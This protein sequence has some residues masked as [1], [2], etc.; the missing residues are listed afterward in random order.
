MNRY[1]CKK[2]NWSGA[3]VCKLADPE[4]LANILEHDISLEKISFDTAEN[5]RLNFC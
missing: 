2:L 1:V 4:K 3:E 5:E